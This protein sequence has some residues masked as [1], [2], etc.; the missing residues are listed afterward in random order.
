MY[1]AG[2]EYILGFQKNADTIVMGPCIPKKWRE[3][4]IQY[5]YLETTY[6]ITVNNP[7]GLSKGVCEITVDGAAASGNRFA[8]VND[9]AT[10][11]VQVTMGLI[12][13]YG[14]S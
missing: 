14:N 2:L 9:G 11:D 3:Y 5:R 8:L 6:D 7:N 13:T 12:E 1:R 10:H 4:S